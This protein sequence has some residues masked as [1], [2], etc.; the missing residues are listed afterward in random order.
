M[1]GR[2]NAPPPPSAGGGKSRGPEGRGLIIATCHCGRFSGG[3]CQKSSL[4]FLQFYAWYLAP[5]SHNF[6]SII[7][8]K[9]WTYS[10]RSNPCSVFLT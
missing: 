9:N 2:S 10:L 5:D 6:D 4:I 8:L 1:G 7:L 3:G